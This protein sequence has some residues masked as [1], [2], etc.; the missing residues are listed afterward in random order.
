MYNPVKSPSS[1]CRRKTMHSQVEARVSFRLTTSKPTFAMVATLRYL[2]TSLMLVSFFEGRVPCCRCICMRHKSRLSACV[3]NQA[4]RL[5]NGRCLLLLSMSWI[6][7]RLITESLV[8]L[9][10]TKTWQASSSH[11][12]EI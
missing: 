12:G 6:N 4:V 7:V 2:L 10:K 1:T 9:V 11:G 5:V 3:A 8:I